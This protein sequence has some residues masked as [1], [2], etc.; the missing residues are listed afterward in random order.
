MDVN[1]WEDP[2]NPFGPCP[3]QGGKRLRKCCLTPIG[4]I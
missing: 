4:T 2:P 1:Y 3:C